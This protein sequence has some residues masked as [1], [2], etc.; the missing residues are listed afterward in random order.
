MKSQTT[1]EF[2]AILAGTILV[3][4]IIMIYLYGGTSKATDTLVNLT[5]SQF[6]IFSF[7]LYVSTS[8][9]Y[10]YGTYYQTGSY[11]Y[12]NATF[13]IKINQT[14]YSV[15]IY[16]TNHLSTI[17]SYI[18]NFKSENAPTNLIEK[19]GVGN[20]Q[21]TLEYIKFK[22]GNENYMFIANQTALSKTN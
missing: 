16:S 14:S 20:V 18:F 4:T 10:I 12:N 9:N 17:G 11:Q 22:Y 15:P 1:I 8:G 3:A 19:L 2:V 13:G 6:N 7:N 21:Y 5:S